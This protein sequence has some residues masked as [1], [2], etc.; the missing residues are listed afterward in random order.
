[1]NR[2]YPLVMRENRF[3]VGERCL[4]DVL[5]VTIIAAGACTSHGRAFYIAQLEDKNEVL[6]QVTAGSDID[7]FL[8]ITM[9][10][11]IWIWCSE[12]KLKMEISNYARLGPVRSRG[13]KR[14]PGD[15]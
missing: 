14:G 10:R 9:C 5:E 13:S 2:A 11:P 4:G 1:M 8:G 6:L 15:N 12:N 7:K 3:F